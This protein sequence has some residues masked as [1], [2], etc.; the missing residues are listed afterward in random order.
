[1]SDRDGSNHNNDDGSGNNSRN[2][3]DPKKE[4]VNNSNE[5]DGNKPPNEEKKDL[6]ASNDPTVDSSKKVPEKDNIVNE[7]SENMDNKNNN[8]SDINKPLSES[9]V[10]SKNGEQ[11]NPENNGEKENPEKK[12][13]EN[14]GEKENPEKENPENNGEKE[15]PEK[16][17]PENNGEQENPEKENPENNKAI[18]IIEPTNDDKTPVETKSAVDL[19]NHINWNSLE[20][21]KRSTLLDLNYYFNRVDKVFDSIDLLKD[22]LNLKFTEVDELINN[23]EVNLSKLKEEEAVVYIDDKIETLDDLITVAKKYGNPQPI[24]KFTVDVK[25]M[26][27]IIKPLEKL[28]GMIGLGPIKDQL[29]DQIL[30]SLQSLYEDDLM[31]HTVIYGP[32]GV[33]KTMLARIIGEIYL[34]MG[35]L[36]PNEQTGEVIF[37]E[38]RRSDLIGKYLGHTAVKTQE[39]IDKCEGGVLFIDEVYA[40]GNTEKKDSFSKECIDTLNQNLTEKKNFIC[41]IAGYPTEVEQCFFNY[42][43]GLKRRFPFT[44]DI[45]GYSSGELKDIFVAKIRKSGWAFS[46]D[47]EKDM[48]LIDKLFEKNLSSFNNFGGDIDTLITNSKIVHGRRIFGKDFSIR[49]KLTIEDITNGH[50]KMIDFKREHKNE[51]DNYKLTSMYI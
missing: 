3:D 27:K 9:T 14:N 32:P 2:G 26:H 15:N 41:I 18:V 25:I 17:N 13:P 45:P 46:E 11:E 33:G 24:R 12:N 4:E 38:A 48:T 23:I 42:N 8:I 44:Y 39:F 43:P 28:K 50:K 7:E 40:L 21:E 47:I 22:Q 6:P 31:F 20:T 37:K 49:R 35:I 34:N 51:M 19:I 16:E 5:D 36:K 29:V 1:M 30:T 10:E